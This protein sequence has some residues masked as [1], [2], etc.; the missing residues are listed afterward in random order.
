MNSFLDKII[1][2]IVAI[3]IFSIQNHYLPLTEYTNLLLLV[4]KIQIVEYYKNKL[5]KMFSR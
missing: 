4:F 1:L 5:R 2:K 3:T